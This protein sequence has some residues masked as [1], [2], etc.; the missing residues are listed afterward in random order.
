MTFFFFFFFFLQKIYSYTLINKSL[1]LTSKQQNL[2]LESM[3]Q[4]QKLR[5]KEGVD[6]DEQIIS[7][8]EQEE[9]SN[10]AR[11][12]KVKK[13]K[14][15]QELPTKKKQVNKK[16]QQIESDSSKLVRLSSNPDIEVEEKKN[17]KKS[18]IGKRKKSESDISNTQNE[19]EDVEL[20]KKKTKSKRRRKKKNIFAYRF[21]LI[22]LKKIFQKKEIS[23]NKSTSFDNETEFNNPSPS[24]VEQINELKS[25][26]LQIKDQNESNKS[27]F[28]LIE[29]NLMK[30]QNVLVERKLQEFDQLNQEKLKQ[31]NA[32]KFEEF[33]HKFE[34]LLKQKD[35]QI[36]ELQHSNEQL[37][38]QFS[39]YKVEQEK[40][41][42]K[43]EQ[44]W[45]FE[46]ESLQESINQQKKHFE[47][48]LFEEFQKKLVNPKIPPNQVNDYSTKEIIDQSNQVNPKKIKIR[49]I[50]SESSTKP[51]ND[52]IINIDSLNTTNTPKTLVQA[53]TNKNA[54]QQQQS[55]SLPKITIK[56]I[57]T[58]NENDKKFFNSRYLCLQEGNLVEEE[59]IDWFLYLT[60][61]KVISFSFYFWKII[62]FFA[63]LI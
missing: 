50:K 53:F 59:I 34:F 51:H 60:S 41:L 54:Q 42:K 56:K 19:T 61:K 16:D 55:L 22:H 35:K 31:V 29:E 6:L 62:N 3:I 24:T 21:F 49:I 27:L 10:Q 28:L 46:I 14:M 30:S 58:L 45:K 40:E 4:K 38:A 44:I 11:K 63:Y 52:D 47:A 17:Q 18:S 25:Q 8:V 23:R 5:K 7:I 32:I 9:A 15:P 2:I 12:P 48:K 57:I 26:I 43:L 1:L 39:Q 37:I 13:I 36:E 20:K 33:Q